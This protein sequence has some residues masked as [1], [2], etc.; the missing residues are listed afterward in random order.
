MKP[1]P[2]SLLLAARP[3]AAGLL[4]LLAGC[5]TQPGSATKPPPAA[6]LPAAFDGHLTKERGESPAP[7]ARDWW[8]AFNDATLDRLV[9]HALSANE[10]I[11]IADARLREAEAGYAAA[12]TG[13]EPSV[14]AVAEYRRQHLPPNDR[15]R[16]PLISQYAVTGIAASWDADLFGR[17]RSLAEAARAGVRAGRAARDDAALAVSS[18]LARTYLEYRG[19]QAALVQ[20]HRIRDL[21]ASEVGWIRRRIDAGLAG[22]AELAEASMRLDAQD[23]DLAD[24]GREHARTLHR[25]AV[26][27]AEPADRLRTL[28]AEPAPLAPEPACPPQPSPALLLSRRADIQQAA[29][30]L[31]AAR[32]VV[33][34]SQAELLPRLTFSGQLSFFAF[35]WG[36]GPN[37]QWDL[38]DRARV[39]AR[40]ARAAAQ[41]D[42][43]VARY[44]RTVRLAVS[45][46]EDA[47]SDLDAA[48]QRRD[49]LKAA[50]GQA[51]LL[52]DY[53]RQRLAA[54]L[55]TRIDL[56]D[57]QVAEAR[58]RLE[59]DAQESA[60]RRAWVGLFTAL[61][62]G[63]PASEAPKADAK[64][65]PR[66]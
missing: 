60:V 48:R 11:L 33:D 53:A 16:D 47:L 61:G 59:L 50:A 49:S 58:A 41:A 25:L 19:E 45:E 66:R 8:T 43:A 3:L 12:R 57:A 18:A 37:L 13:R 51:G 27:A 38:F 30:E 29:Q 44:Q 17:V 32:A 4:T 5:A 54:G 20:A 28:L 56:A 26:L 65:D 9:S 34:A 40:E 15:N 36:L 39:K 1:R 21:R 31:V 14:D 6:P 42:E 24:L 63:G 52:A 22:R 35:G 62:G 10:D 23:A 7:V 2:T 55:A 64:I 46:V